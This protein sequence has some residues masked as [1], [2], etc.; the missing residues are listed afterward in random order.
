VWWPTPCGEEK[1]RH[2]YSFEIFQKWGHSFEI[3]I[4]NSYRIKF[5]LGPLHPSLVLLMDY[6]IDKNRAVFRKS[7]KIGLD[8]FLR[9]TENQS[10]TIQKIQILNFFEK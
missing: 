8:R 7:D 6:N 4:L 5:C 1:W 3:S 2:A 10:V 9:F